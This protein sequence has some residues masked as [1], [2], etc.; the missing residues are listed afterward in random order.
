[1]Y[2]SLKSS[3]IQAIEELPQKNTI[4]ILTLLR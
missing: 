4:H 3:W 1:L 2:W